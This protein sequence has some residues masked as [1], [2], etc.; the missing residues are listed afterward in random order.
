MYLTQR[1]QPSFQGVW[2]RV[3]SMMNVG[4]GEDLIQFL[5]PAVLARKTTRAIKSQSSQEISWWIIKGKKIRAYWDWW[6]SSVQKGAYL[7]RR[8]VW[9]WSPG[10]K[11]KCH[12]GGVLYN[13][14]TGNA[15]TRRL[16]DSLGASLVY[17][18]SSRPVRDTVFKKEIGSGGFSGTNMCFHFVMVVTQEPDLIFFCNFHMHTSAHTRVPTTSASLTHTSPCKL[19][20]LFLN[21]PFWYDKI[22]A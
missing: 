11:Y 18:M 1:E 12:V 8:R 16:G 4:A 10:S 7:T 2:G 22:F 13:P 19:D 17:F 15:E 3:L 9:V 14:S 20:C 6:D 21:Y 5:L